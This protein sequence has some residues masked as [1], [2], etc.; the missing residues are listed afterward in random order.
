MKSPPLET[1]FNRTPVLID[2]LQVYGKN[3][4][5]KSPVFEYKNKDYGAKHFEIITQVFYLKEKICEVAHKPRA[6]ILK[7][8]SVLIKFENSLLY[9]P[10]LPY[11]I[12]LLFSSLKFEPQHITRLDLCVDFPTFKNKLKPN[13]F[14]NK[15][16]QNKILKIGRGTFKLVGTQKRIN[17]YE[18]LRFGSNISD[19]SAYLYNKSKELNEVKNKPYIRSLWYWQKSELDSWI[20]TDVWRLEFSIKN[21]KLNYYYPETGEYIPLNLESVLKYESREFIYKCLMNHYFYFVYNNGKEKKSRMKTVPLLNLENIGEIHIP[22]AGKESNRMQKIF[23]TMFEEFNNENRFKDRLKDSAA[24]QILKDYVSK[25][26]LSGWHLKRTQSKK[27][28]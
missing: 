23:I 11:V 15:F 6:S 26:G 27:N 25:Y 16:L 14:I 9:K 24:D 4:E 5:F 8:E 28:K 12:N 22:K 10:E 18:Y 19:V 2:W 17:Q 1:G 20:N 3:C 21:H 7:P 13:K